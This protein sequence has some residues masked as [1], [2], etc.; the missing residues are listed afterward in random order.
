[1]QHWAPF[2]T[3]HTTSVTQA[4]DGPQQPEDAETRADEIQLQDEREMAALGRFDYLS[5]S[6]PSLASNSVEAKIFMFSIPLEMVYLLC[7]GHPVRVSRCR[8]AELSSLL[9]HIWR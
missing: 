5:V 8:I 4:G 1:M 2:P 6:S 7:R 3:A 9:K